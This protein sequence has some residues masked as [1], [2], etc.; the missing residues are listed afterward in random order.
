M[1]TLCLFMAF[2]LLKNLTT[3]NQ[4]NNQTK[5]IIKSTKNK[6]ESNLN[7]VKQDSPK[8][9]IHGNDSTTANAKLS[10]KK[11]NSKKIDTINSG[12]LSDISDETRTKLNSLFDI[13]N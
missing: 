1:L 10:D 12:D 13:N 8:I 9:E 3:D 7:Q 6:I 5:N 2:S 11:I 4:N